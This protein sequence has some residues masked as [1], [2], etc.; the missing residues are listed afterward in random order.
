MGDVEEGGREGDSLRFSGGST[1]TLTILGGRLQP[2]Y[3]NQLSDFDQWLLSV[4]QNNQYSSSQKDLTYFE[5]HKIPPDLKTNNA[6]YICRQVY[7]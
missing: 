2:P 5:N 1:V 7:H 4:N 6:G 3:C